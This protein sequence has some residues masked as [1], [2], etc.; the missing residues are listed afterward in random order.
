MN[1]H[2]PA[3]STLTKTQLR[4]EMKNMFHLRWK[5]DGVKIH[6]PDPNGCHL[7]AFNCMIMY[8]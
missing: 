4:S 6:P 1:I 8:N 2:Y 5:R 7:L 3:E